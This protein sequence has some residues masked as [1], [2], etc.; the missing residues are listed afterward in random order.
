[1][2]TLKHFFLFD[3]VQILENYEYT[4]NTWDGEI[5]YPSEN[6]YFLNLIYFSIEDNSENLRL[7]EKS[8]HLKIDEEMDPGNISTKD[9]L[10]Y[11]QY[12]NNLQFRQIKDHI[13]SLERIDSLDKVEPPRV[14]YNIDNYESIIKKFN[15]WYNRNGIISPITR[16]DYDFQTVQEAENKIILQSR[17]HLFEKISWINKRNQIIDTAVSFINN[18]IPKLI[19]SDYKRG[20][21]IDI[22]VNAYEDL[23]PFNKGKKEKIINV[24]DYINEIFP[25][26]NHKFSEWTIQQ[27]QKYLS[28]LISPKQSK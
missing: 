18:E 1:M 14:N 8:Y 4:E 13:K 20:D 10:R 27:F 9:P 5:S 19:K 28:P 12:H 11:C 23:I 17:L 25:K 7:V 24:T 16:D 3:N 26:I 21:I 2:S 6:A 15:D 22:C